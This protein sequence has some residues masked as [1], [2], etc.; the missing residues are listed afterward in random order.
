MLC[1]CV[2]PQA[3]HRGRSQT[4]V[5]TTVSH[6]RFTVACQSTPWGSVPGLCWAILLP[7]LA[8]SYPV[9]DP[10]SDTSPRPR[11]LNPLCSHTLALMGRFI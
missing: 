4:D 7:A 2:E 8:R 11:P 10:I 5:A 9:P 6:T 3:H 1:S